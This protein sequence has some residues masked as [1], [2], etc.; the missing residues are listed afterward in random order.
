MDLNFSNVLFDHQEKSIRVVD[1]G[2]AN[3]I[4]IIDEYSPSGNP[5]FRPPSEKKIK[6]FDADLWGVWLIGQGI[7]RGRA[8]K[9]KEL[10]AESWNEWMRGEA[11]LKLECSE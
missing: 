5:K 10:G 1:F 8:I 11:G 9:T 4:N 7:L 6:A 2:V 3:Y